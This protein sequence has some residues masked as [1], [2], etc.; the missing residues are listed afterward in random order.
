[1]EPRVAP[2]AAMFDIN[3]DFLLNC[4]D[5][6]SDEEAGRCLA[7]GG[8]SITFLAAHLADSRQFLVA[9]L[10]ALLNN[11][12]ARYLANARNIEQ[13]QEW[14]SL[15][16]V[17]EAWLAVGAHLERVLDSLTPATVSR[18]SANRFP[19][20]DQTELGMIAFLAQHESYHVGQMAF[21]RRQLGK[22]AMS[23]TRAPRPVSPV[24]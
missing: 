10:D 22:P 9:R 19:I 17:R 15:V 23:Y 8:N 20:G 1:M 4:L 6:L 18:A 11:P 13:I 12:L 16:E 2:L 21:L 7:A 5:G 14:P 3:T 24:A